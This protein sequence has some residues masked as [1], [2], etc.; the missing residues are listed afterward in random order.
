MATPAIGKDLL[1]IRSAQADAK[2]GW[3]EMQFEGKPIWVSPMSKISSEDMTSVE[4]MPGNSDYVLSL[5][6]TRYGGKM[7]ER[8]TKQDIGNVLAIIYEGDVLFAPKIRA[9]ISGRIITIM[10]SLTEAEAQEM[11][12]KINKA[13]KSSKRFQNIIPPSSANARQYQQNQDGKSLYATLYSEVSN[14][15]PIE[16]IMDLLGDGRLM[17]D[18][19]IKAMMPDMKKAVSEYPEEF[20]D[21]IQDKD[22]L[23]SYPAGKPQNILLM[24]RDGH[25][26][27]YSKDKFEEYREFK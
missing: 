16:K 5:T 12:D 9:P 13:I 25:L 11:A 24:F 10:G 26:I 14:V 17:E 2:A 27:N 15:D 1:E 18:D 22:V 6:L 4:V 21:G 19:T 7:L 3:E 23:V 20:P 8:L